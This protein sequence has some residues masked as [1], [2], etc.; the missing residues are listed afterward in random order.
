MEV[1]PQTSRLRILTS[2]Y[3]ETKPRGKKAWQCFVALDSSFLN[4]MPKTQMKKIVKLD[5]I[6]N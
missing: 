6:K 4:M 1:T 2:H 3:M 5:C